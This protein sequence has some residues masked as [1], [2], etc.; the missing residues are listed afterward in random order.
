MDNTRD[1]HM[2]V[3]CV[4]YGAPVSLRTRDEMPRRVTYDVDLTGIDTSV[5]RLFMHVYTWESVRTVSVLT[6]TYFS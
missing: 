2:M 6:F 4:I 1:T 5:Y 3:K